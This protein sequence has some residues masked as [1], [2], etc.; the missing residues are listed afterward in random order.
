M[1]LQEIQV[2]KYSKT[3]PKGLIPNEIC[4]QCPLRRIGSTRDLKKDP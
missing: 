1:A 3:D 4:F 2:I